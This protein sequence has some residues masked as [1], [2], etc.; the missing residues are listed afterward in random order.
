MSVDT[1]PAKI[2]DDEE[3]FDSEAR[4]SSHI[5]YV[6]LSSGFESLFYSQIRRLK[7]VLVEDK[8]LFIFINPNLVLL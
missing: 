7:M 3:E 6:P 1:G 5:A 2:F 4:S 8:L